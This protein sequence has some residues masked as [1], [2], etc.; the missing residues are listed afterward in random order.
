MI[1]RGKQYNKKIQD[2][3]VEEAVEDRDGWQDLL[4]ING[5]L[6]RTKPRKKK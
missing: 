1:Q 3:I 5:V 2:I 6:L 4:I